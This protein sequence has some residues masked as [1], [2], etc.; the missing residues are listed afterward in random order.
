MR[1]NADPSFLVG[2]EQLVWVAIKE[3]GA[4]QRHTGI[5]YRN[6]SNKTMLLH[7]AFHHM[8]RHDELVDGNSFYFAQVDLDPD[9]QTVIAAFA[10]L[11]GNRA[12]K[13]P[14]GF[15][16]SGIVIDDQGQVGGLELGKGLTCATFVLAFFRRFA[17]EVINVG[18]WPKREDDEVW[19]KKMIKW[20]SAYGAGGDHIAALEKN[21]LAAR[22]RPEEV[23][24]A[25][26]E[27]VDSWPVRFEN[28]LKFA[29]EVLA[30]IA[31]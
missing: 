1:V 7:L 13:I 26:A 31:A 12:P 6:D 23:V 4:E 9:N 30:D 5:V 19:Q 11:F 3:T 27:G 16:A 28:A 22:F 29:E 17:F 15:D 14:Y 24:G 21:G 8:L 10:E 20:M 2:D 18:T 25:V